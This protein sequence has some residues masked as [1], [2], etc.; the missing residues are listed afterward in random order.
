MP[1][2]HDRAL[3]L[4]VGSRREIRDTVRIS[5]IESP[6]H[7]QPSDCPVHRPGVDVTVVQTF[8]NHPGHGTFAR[9]RWTV[10]GDDEG[11]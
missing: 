2:D 6:V 3:E 4:E 1:V 10:D 11:P 5:K 8:G 9:T 7:R